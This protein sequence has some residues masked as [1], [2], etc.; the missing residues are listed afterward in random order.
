MMLVIMTKVT[1]KIVR[2]G[3]QPIVTEGERILLGQRKNVFHSG[4]WGLPGGHLEPG[5][6][7]LHAC[8]RELFEETGILATEMRLFC[9]TDPTAESNY[10]M[11]IGI[12]V[13]R[14]EGEPQI[15]E[16]N[17]CSAL[18]FFPFDDLPQPIFMSSVDVI[19]NYVERVFYRGVYF[20]EDL[21]NLM[22]EIKT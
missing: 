19:K 10:H 4:S 20:P 7:L 18:G 17:L 2:V 5:E 21:Q 11:Q 16:P 3:V 12:E 1:E 6:S 22:K 9:V 15:M 13:L 8:A 14:Y